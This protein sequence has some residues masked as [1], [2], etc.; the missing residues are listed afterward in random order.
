MTVPACP[1]RP[2]PPPGPRDL[3]RAS[4]AELLACLLGANPPTRL[5]Q[6]DARRLLRLHGGLPGLP[7]AAAAESA[8]PELRAWQ[9]R[10]EAAAEIRRRQEWH[11]L[12]AGG[13]L[14]T[15]AEAL[16]FL[17]SA[18]RDRRREVVVGLFLD[19]RHRVIACEELFR[20][21][22]DGAPVHPRVVAAR[23][24]RLNAAAVIMAHN[25]PSGCSEPSRADEVIT[26]RLRDAL[27]LLEVR[28][29]DHFV[30]GLGAPVSLASRGVL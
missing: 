12:R 26:Q 25:H 17:A 16:A 21:S 19:T 27:A 23:A 4:D 13:P 7:L 14:T 2:A 6:R 9:H 15:P 1:A 30:I 22:I 3:R 29:L 18:L 28:L 24:L 11:G 10:M 20:G 5:D 8:P